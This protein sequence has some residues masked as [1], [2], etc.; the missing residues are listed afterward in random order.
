MKSFDTSKPPVPVSGEGDVEDQ[1][2]A[3]SDALRDLRADAGQKATFERWLAESP[4]HGKAFDKVE[5]AYRL[6]RSLR[7]SSSL[8]AMENETLARVAMQAGRGRRRAGRQRIAAIAA[9]L[10]VAILGGLFATGGSWDQLMFLQERAR[11]ALAGETLYRTAVGERLAVTLD[12]SSVLTLNTG[13]RAVVRYRDGV[14]GVTLI[15]GQALFEVAK[16]PQHPFVVVAGGRKVTALGTAFDVRLSKGS[17][18]VTLIEGKVS[19]EPESAT[20]EST[21]KESTLLRAELAP[22]EQLVA[23]AD[24]PAPIIRK[25][26]VKRTTS[27]RNG[28][29]LFENDT[30]ATAVEEINRY[31]RRHV[32]LADQRLGALRVSGAF[33]TS[34]TAVFIDMLT[35]YLPVRVVEADGDR[36]VLGYRDE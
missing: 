11:Y 28:Q 34:D 25:A 22:G 20:A 13:S 10:V 35:V 16:D 30:L 15:E 7:G 19:V 2:A 32:V 6:A 26:N 33:N 8:I 18:E 27:W 3:W 14:R 1:A 21:P 4:E 31:G 12:D 36:I 23:L 29:V 9:C 17:L 5:R 24:A